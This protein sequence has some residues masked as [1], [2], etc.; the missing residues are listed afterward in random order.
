MDRKLLDALIEAEP[1]LK[2]LEEHVVATS[3]VTDSHDGTIHMP[4][5]YGDI[6]EGFKMGFK[7]G[8]KEVQHEAAIGREGMQDSE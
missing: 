5:L 1:K 4:A 8:M 2:A 7:A 6:V 3:V